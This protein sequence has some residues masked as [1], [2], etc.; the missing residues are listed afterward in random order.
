M[1]I[2][3]ISGNLKIKRVTP[4]KIKYLF[5][6]NSFPGD[7]WAFFLFRDSR[8]FSCGEYSKNDYKKN[9]KIV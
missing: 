3:F 6:I 1:N 9:K 4:Q 2:F 5:P 8:V 7:I